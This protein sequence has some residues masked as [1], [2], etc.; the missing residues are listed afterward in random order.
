MANRIAEQIERTIFQFKWL[1]MPPKAKYAYLWN[2]SRASL[3]AD[4]YGLR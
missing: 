3:Q 2:R 1:F 4:Y